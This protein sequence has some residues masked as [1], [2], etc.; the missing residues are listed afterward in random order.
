MESISLLPQ[1]RKIFVFPLSYIVF[2]VN[3]VLGM[4]YLPSESILFHRRGVFF[5]RVIA[6]ARGMVVR[7]L[8]FRNKHS[9]K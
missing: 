7:P 3:S 8:N 5:Q 9:K 4:I 1:K 2:I 6:L